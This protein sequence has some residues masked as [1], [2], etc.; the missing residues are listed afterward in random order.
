MCDLFSDVLW[1]AMATGC[2]FQT[3][4]NALVENEQCTRGAFAQVK[5]GYS[6][7]LYCDD[8]VMQSKNI[9]D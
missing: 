5:G 1:L 2:T 8:K 3:A 4:Y 6:T 7:K 9:L